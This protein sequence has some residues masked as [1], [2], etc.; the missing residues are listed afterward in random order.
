MST[1]I[2]SVAYYRIATAKQGASIPAQRAQVEACAAWHGFQIARKHQEEA[3]SGND[4]GL[5][6]TPEKR[7]EGQ[8]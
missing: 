8:Q 7:K 2:P 4:L 3:I 5:D 1:L 6:L